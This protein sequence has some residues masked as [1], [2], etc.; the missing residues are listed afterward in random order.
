MEFVA[1]AAVLGTSL[2]AASPPALAQSLLQRL[3]GYGARSAPDSS[4]E[5]GERYPYSRPGYEFR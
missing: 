5:R 2:A 1:G 4:Y 3:F